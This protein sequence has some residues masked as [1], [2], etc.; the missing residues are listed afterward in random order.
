MR[1]SSLTLDGGSDSL[2]LKA[3][4]AAQDIEEVEVRAHCARV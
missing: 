4:G 3:A 2:C 1:R